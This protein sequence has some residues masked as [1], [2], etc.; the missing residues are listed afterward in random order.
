M[1][2]CR[3][4][5]LNYA[6]KRIIFHLQ[7]GI[8]LKDTITRIASGNSHASRE[9]LQCNRNLHGTSTNFTLKHGNGSRVARYEAWNKSGKRTFA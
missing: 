5:T 1:W 2:L 7:E 8:T 4:I 6:R 9:L 3:N